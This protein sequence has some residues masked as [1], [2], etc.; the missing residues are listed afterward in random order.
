MRSLHRNPWPIWP[1]FDVQTARH[2]LEAL[3]SARLPER[4]DRPSP[5]SMQLESK[6]I[7]KLRELCGFDR[8]VLT[9]SGRLAIVAALHALF[10]DGVKRR[11]LVPAS[12]WHGCADAVLRA[13]HKP[14]FIDAGPDGEAINLSDLEKRKPEEIG[15]VLAVHNFASI[16]D[17]AEIRGVMPDVPV[18]EDAAHLV[19]HDW[20]PSDMANR[21]DVSI[22]SFQITKLLTGLEGGA[23]LTNSPTLSQRAK[24][25]TENNVVKTMGNG[26]CYVAG[27]VLSAQ[28]IGLLCDQMERFA[29][30]CFRR[31]KG[32]SVFI[33]T[34]R[35]S[36]WRPLASEACLSS[37][38]LYGLPLLL[39]QST[40]PDVAT[41]IQDLRVAKGLEVDL[42]YEPIHNSA[43]FDGRRDGNSFDAGRSTEVA[44]RFFHRCIVVP[45]QAFLA[46]PEVLVDLAQWLDQWARAPRPAKAN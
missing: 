6:L 42:Y 1:E 26:S 19:S 9:S 15:C 4:L 39:E 10:P 8:V 34:L 18:I 41:L 36:H 5:S 7:A 35:N 28:T 23:L 24:A 3:A 29:D 11:V 14:V 44:D 46:T 32:L 27:G 16:C 30:Q 21:A 37:G 22:V 2:V 25:F 43:L 40:P 45:H 12:T 33:D 31:I 17:I 20:R 38:Q 13:G